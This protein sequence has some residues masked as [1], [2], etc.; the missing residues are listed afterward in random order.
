[1]AWR[2]I[3]NAGSRLRAAISSTGSFTLLY[4]RR[5]I[6]DLNADTA[7][8]E[9]QGSSPSRIAG[10]VSSGNGTDFYGHATVGETWVGAKTGY[11]ASTV[12]QWTWRLIV[13][14]GTS[15]RFF[16]APDNA[17]SAW[18]EWA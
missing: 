14:N 9:F 2:T 10:I 11:V 4:A 1:M 5:Q 16:S 7:E 12:G 8:L 15:L 13:G 18:T 17:S 6:T 3:N